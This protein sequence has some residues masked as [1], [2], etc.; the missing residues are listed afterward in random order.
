MEATAKIAAVVLAAGASSRMGRH[1]L[2]LELGGESLLRR[3]VRRVS[4]AGFEQV[5]V[6]LG[7]DGPQL[8]RE[9]RGLAVQCALNPNYERGL[10]T[11]FRAGIEALAPAIEAIVFTHADRPFLTSEH[12]RTVVDAYVARLAPVVASRYGDVIAPPHLVRR[13]LTAEMATNESSVRPLLQR[14]DVIFVDLPE[15]ALFDVDEPSD[16]ER[17]KVLIRAE[18][19]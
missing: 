16:Y 1:K 17:A 18:P 3:A 19:L 12:F 10:G 8:E 15:F 7:R 6:V 9:L 14:P 13:D 4:A 2:L 11:S 5:V